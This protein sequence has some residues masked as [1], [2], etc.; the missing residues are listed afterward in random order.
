MKNQQKNAPADAP[1][2]LQF[3]RGDRAK[4]LIAFACTV[5]NV[6]ITVT[7]I[8]N[9]LPVIGAEFN[10][11]ASDMSLLSVMYSL[12]ISALGLPFGRLGDRIGYDKV[13]VSGNIIFTITTILS[14][15]FTQSFV[16]V[17]VFR[18]LMGVGAS[19]VQSISQ[20]LLIRSM[21][22]KDR[23][24]A[25]SINTMT[26]SFTS[27][28][29]P[30]LGSLVC[31]AMGWRI[32]FVM[33]VPFGVAGIICNWKFVRKFKGTGNPG[34]PVGT[35]LFI[36]FL[37]PLMLF[38]NKHK[39]VWV[40]GA[41][42]YG[43]LALAVVALVIFVIW[44]GRAKFPLL[45]PA[46]FADPRFAIAAIGIL[47]C[48]IATNAS[49]LALPFYLQSALGMSTGVS[50]ILSVVFNIAMVICI[51][52]FGRLSDK[53]GA[54]KLSISG[55]AVML[56]A[57]IMIVFYRLTTGV[58]FIIISQA[59]QGIASAMFM[60]PTS[61]VL[62]GVTPAEDFGI[63]SATISTMRNLAG[64]VGGTIYSV[65]IGA[66]T[67][68]YQGQG[69]TDSALVYTKAQ[70]DFSLVNMLLIAVALVLMIV[71]RILVKKRPADGC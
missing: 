54:T 58:V 46:L 16:L 36:L 24:F 60:S 49:H 34:D 9:I 44:E 31:N 63:A 12:I 32:S 8:N 1:G 42:G 55:M 37:V 56:V 69:L 4:L 70:R 19:M 13:F 14:G 48:Y 20:V 40:Q 7:S 59:L 65:M 64:A 51:T 28:V 68:F 43:L 2:E 5:F 18:M 26:V 66:R 10:M 30:I 71:L 27:I 23:G 11:G 29:A 21:P 57:M 52:P 62:L 33:M 17:V 3:G 50:S 22:A 39:L 38:F 41:L 35:L 6:F 47:C 25:I 61:S 15:I 53:I 67:L 45:K